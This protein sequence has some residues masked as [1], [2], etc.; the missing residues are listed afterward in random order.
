MA[1][2]A[3]IRS[4]NYPQSD[5][6]LKTRYLTLYNIVSAILWFTVLG[7]TLI[8][9]PLVGYANIHGGVGEF[10]RWTQCLALIEVVNSAVGVVRAPL[11]TTLLQVSSRLILILV[12]YLFPRSTI[13][14]P[15]YSSMLL[16]WSATEV[17]RYSY[18]GFSLYL[19]SSKRVPGLLTWL[20]YNMFFVLYPVGIGSECWLMWSS[21]AEAEGRFGPAAKW[22]LW[23]VLGV[24]VPGSY[25]LYTHMMAQRRKVIKGKARDD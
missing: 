23:A 12:I 16:A 9:V 11:P 3:Q 4:Q 20:R 2:T 8:L 14:S 25:I 13:T 22:A 21:M 18:F 24:Y 5:V 17:V 6:P 15:A 1:S 10:V 19:N 7:R